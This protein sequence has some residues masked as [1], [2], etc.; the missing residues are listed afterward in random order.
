MSCAALDSGDYAAEPIVNGIL[1]AGVPGVISAIFKCFKSMVATDLAVSIAT[2]SAFLGKFEVPKPM[3]VAYFSGEGGPGVC[4]DYARRIAESKGRRLCDVN[5]LQFCFTVPQLESIDDLAEFSKALDTI[6]PAVVIL[7]NLMLCVSGQDAGNAFKMANVLGHAIRICAERGTTLVMIHHHKRHQAGAEKYRLPELSDLTQA[8]TAE[9][10]GQWLQLNRRCEYDPDHPGHHELNMTVGGRLGQSGGWA[11]NI[12]E[13]VKND[14]GNRV[15]NVSVL[16]L[17]EA[18]EVKAAEVMIDTTKRLN[19]AMQAF[20][21]GE[22]QEVI[23]AKAGGRDTN[24]KSALAGLLADGTAER[25]DIQK[26]NRKKPYPGYKIKETP[27][28]GSY[29]NTPYHLPLP[30]REAWYHHPTPRLYIGGGGWVVPACCD[31]RPSPTERLDHD[32]D[33]QPPTRRRPARDL[34]RTPRWV[35]RLPVTTPSTR[36]SVRL[37]RIIQGYRNSWASWGI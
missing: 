27:R 17:S 26:P 37:A 8:G 3:R 33:C 29:R 10:V 1:Y 35:E 15:W 22:T 7:D 34:R 14:W 19:V 24:L 16:P 12:E 18:R 4:Q 20:P 36:S 30:A 11:L 28:Y 6:K 9:I 2:G 25:C 5:A 13:G 23:F 31:E 32:N 21:E